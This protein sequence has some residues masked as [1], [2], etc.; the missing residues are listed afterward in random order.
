L[1]RHPVLLRFTQT[2]IQQYLANNS[3]NI[4]NETWKYLIC[5]LCINFTDVSQIVS[6]VLSWL[7]TLHHESVYQFCIDVFGIKYKNIISTDSSKNK[8]KLI[9]EQ[10]AQ[11]ILNLNNNQTHTLPFEFQQTEY[12]RDVV[13][14]VVRIIDNGEDVL[15]NIKIDSFSNAVAF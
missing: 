12:D 14:E 1:I 15:P 6:R 3:T 9:F 7:K 11:C 2:C 10:T 5:T 4:S 8:N 13:N